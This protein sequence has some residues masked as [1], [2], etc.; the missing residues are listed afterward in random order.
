[1]KFGILWT[2]RVDLDD[3]PDLDLLHL[4]EV[5]QPVEDDLPVL[6]AGEI[7]VGDEETQDALR[8]ILPH[9]ALH[10]VG[11]APAGLSALDVDDR[12]ERALERDSRGRR[13]S[14]CSRRRCA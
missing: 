10:I 13:R 5:D 8:R 3:E 14:W 1:M 6:V 4:S 12:A 7:V 9:D 2:E 11:R